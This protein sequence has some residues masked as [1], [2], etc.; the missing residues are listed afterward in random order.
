MSSPIKSLHDPLQDKT[1]PQ[2]QAQE[3]RSVS[4]GRRTLVAVTAAAFLV[5]AAFVVLWQYA[6]LERQITH[7]PGIFAYLAQIVALGYT[8]HK[9]AFN[10]QASLAFIAGGLAMR[11]GDLFGLH[12]LIS[13]RL[14][15]M[16]V[17]AG[18]V[19][20]TCLVGTRFTRS[21]AAG[22][23]AGLILLGYEGYNLR[24]ATALEPKSLMLLLGLASLYFLSRR[25]WVWAGAFA[26]A[27]GLAWQIAWGY[28]IV[29]LL[30][31]VIQ[32][33]RTW[34]ARVRALGLTA[35]AGA[36]VFGIYALYFYSQN[37]LAEMMQ[38]TFIAPLVMRSAANVSLETRVLRLVRTF[39]LGF[40]SHMVFGALGATALVV[41]LGAHLR[42]WEWRRLVRRGVYFS[43]Q[44]RRT[45][46]TLLATFGFLAYSFLDF[47]N[48]PDWFPLLPFVSIFAAWLIWVVFAWVVR[49]LAV[50]KQGRQIAFG[51]LAV[52]VLASS[53]VPAFLQAGRGEP[54]RKGT[55]NEQQAVADEVNAKLPPGS[56]VWVLGKAEFLF[57]MRRVNVNKY[58]YLFGQV[59][60]A[61]DAFEPG[62]FKG[63]FET[64]EAQQPVLFALSRVAPKKYATK[65]NFDVVKRRWD[66]YVMLERCKLLANGKYYVRA[67]LA[68]ALFP[69]GQDGCLKRK[70]K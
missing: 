59:D 33:G 41:W 20:L 56:P 6:P 5:L 34:Q 12:H 54:L 25:K 35:G 53:A 62:G 29:A 49:R 63:V 42:P 31:A 65:S 9:F 23:L 10:E 17:V 26:G 8:P 52:V 47:Q 3:R 24:A 46:G 32:G 55:W 68:D 57:F 30:L 4:T 15:S 66:H 7:D 38:Q 60:A 16:A 58:F 36:G 39:E 28:L 37:A 61:A 69:P 67:D 2:G 48:Y 14:A 21:R 11:A 18:V 19:V 64:V 22:F 27:A 40:G 51:A 50:S 43:F 13:F 44:N 1:L 45:S 70:V